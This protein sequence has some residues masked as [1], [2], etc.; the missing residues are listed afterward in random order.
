MSS[1]FPPL[2]RLCAC[3]LHLADFVTQ[4]GRLFVILLVDGK[5]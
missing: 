2:I 1:G 3:L 4:P 5:L